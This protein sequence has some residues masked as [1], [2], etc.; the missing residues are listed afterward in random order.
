MEFVTTRKGMIFGHGIG[1]LCGAGHHEEELSGVPLLMRG[2]GGGGKKCKGTR[3]QGR[4]LESGKAGIP[5]QLLNR[6]KR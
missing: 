5:P 6:F 3:E 4:F 2:N 1:A